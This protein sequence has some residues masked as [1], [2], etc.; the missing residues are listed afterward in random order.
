[1]RPPEALEQGR[2]RDAAKQVFRRPVTSQWLPWP[3]CHESECAAFNSHTA[4]RQA[5]T[6]DDSL[7]SISKLPLPGLLLV[8]LALLS[9]TTSTTKKL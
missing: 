7:F 3:R 2:A 6:G 4:C 8:L 5:R 9:A 1:M